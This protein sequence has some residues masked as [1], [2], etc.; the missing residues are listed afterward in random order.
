MFR[1]FF[2]S[3]QQIS[4]IGWDLHYLTVLL[5]FS[6]GKGRN[7]AKR[8]PLLLYWEYASML[9]I[10]RMMCTSQHA[11]TEEGTCPVWE[12]WTGTEPA[13]SGR[14]H[15]S[16]CFCEAWTL[17]TDVSISV[18]PGAWVQCENTHPYAVLNL[19]LASTFCISYFHFKA[20]GVL[21]WVSNSP[22]WPGLASPFFHELPPAAENVSI[23][24][25]GS[26]QVGTFS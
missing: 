2:F 1:N 9:T 3:F 22:E 23:L 13:S 6:E 8:R 26:Q 20:C 25:V 21:K 4:S 16:P 15:C 5:N 19:P 7:R 12:T 17:T 14:L 11:G 18:D 24:P 10:Y